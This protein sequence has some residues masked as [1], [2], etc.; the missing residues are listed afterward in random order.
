MNDGLIIEMSQKIDE[1]TYEIQ[2]QSKEIREFEEK[3]LTQDKVIEMYT[4]ENEELKHKVR[5]IKKLFKYI[6]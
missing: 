4:K 6:L 2:A 1:L 3:L 5:K